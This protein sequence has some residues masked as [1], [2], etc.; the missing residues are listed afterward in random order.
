MPVIKNIE[1]INKIAEAKRY[2]IYSGIED[3]KYL[4][5]KVSKSIEDSSVLNEEAAELMRL[6]VAS[7]SIDRIEDEHKYIKSR[8]DRLFI[9]LKK[10]FFDGED[11]KRV[12]VLGSDTVDI[13]NLVPLTKLHNNVI[14]DARTS[15]WIIGRLFKF[16]GLYEIMALMDNSNIIE[17]PLFT[18]NSFLIGPNEHNLMY[19]N[20]AGKSQEVKAT[21]FVKAIAKFIKDWAEPVSDEDNEYMALIN[22]MASNGRDNFDSSHEELYKTIRKLWGK[23]FYQFTYKDRGTLCFK[24]LQEV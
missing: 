23:E 8:Y 5:V 4:I 12:I 16:Y 9:Q 1:I 22:D 21:S 15:A 24:K 3:G 11:L 6:N 20:M 10:S 13:E 14:I 19:Y 17:Y 18:P 7:R 2:D